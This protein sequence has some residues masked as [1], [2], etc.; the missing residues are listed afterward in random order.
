MSS[1]T[2]TVSPSVPDKNSE[3]NA[4]QKLGGFHGKSL[5]VGSSPTHSRP[6]V[7]MVAPVS[8]SSTTND[9]M[10]L[11]LYF[12]ESLALISRALYGKASQGCSSPK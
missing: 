9:G 4:S 3:P 6:S 8:P 7:V 5:P 1:S 2:S 10:P 11:T 12:L